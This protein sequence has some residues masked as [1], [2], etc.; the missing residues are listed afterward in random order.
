MWMEVMRCFLHSMDGKT[1]R[2]KERGEGETRIV[3]Y[4][5]STPP[6]QKNLL[7]LLCTLLK[8]REER[9]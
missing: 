8:G 5:F 3:G 4:F 6:A 7:L 1:E 9:D 2:E